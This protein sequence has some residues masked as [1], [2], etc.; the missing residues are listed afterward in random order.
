MPPEKNKASGV[1]DM[2]SNLQRSI[3][4]SGRFCSSTISSSSSAFASSMSGFSSAAR[5]KSPSRISVRSGYLTSSPSVRFSIDHRHKSPGRSVAASSSRNLNRNCD[6]D[7]SKKAWS[8]GS[9]KTCLCSP[10]TH[11]GS[12][13][14]SL[15]KKS[16]MTNSNDSHD[17]TVSYR[18]HRLYARRSA[19]TNSLVRIGTVEGDLVKR[20]LAALIRPSSH[21]QRRRSDFQPRPSRLSVMCKADE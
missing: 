10:T 20:A 5:S 9:K 11:P 16:S 8:H 7:N 14:C 19:M 13:R 2:R 21:Q 18:S 4:P 1:F 3:S 17:S 6:R 15:H 12:F